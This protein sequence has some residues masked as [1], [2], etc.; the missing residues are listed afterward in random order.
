LLTAARAL[1]CATVD[2][3]GMAVF[4]TAEAF[5]PFTGIAPPGGCWPGFQPVSPAGLILLANHGPKFIQYR[6]KMK[7]TAICGRSGTLR[8]E[9]TES[10]RYDKKEPRNRNEKHCTPSWPRWFTCWL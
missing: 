5:R 2:G 3:G 4:Q 7:A 6:I 8:Q 1:G 9:K 10:V